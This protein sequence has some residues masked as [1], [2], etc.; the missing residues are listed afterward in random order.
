MVPIR[1][2]SL[3]QRSKPPL[4]CLKHWLTGE[5]MIIHDVGQM[6]LYQCI[7]TLT[8]LSCGTEHTA[9]RKTEEETFSMN[10]VSVSGRV[11]MRCA[12]FSQHDAL[13]CWNTLFSERPLGSEGRLSWCVCVCV[14]QCY[15]SGL[16]TLW[17]G[18][19]SGGSAGEVSGPSLSQHSQYRAPGWET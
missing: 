19:G 9:Y 1:T 8:T 16:G 6:I 4:C 13:F 18:C 5:R 10:Y 11:A 15:F 12:P 2:L 7:S 17:S 14:L 3:L